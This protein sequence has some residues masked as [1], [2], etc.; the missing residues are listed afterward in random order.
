MLSIMFLIKA[1]RTNTLSKIP[2]EIMFL[3]IWCWLSESTSLFPSSDAITV[4]CS[5]LMVWP[6]CVGCWILVFFNCC[7]HIAES[8]VALVSKNIWSWPALFVSVILELLSGEHS[9]VGTI[10]K[11]L[12]VASYFRLVLFMMFSIPGEASSMVFLTAGAMTGIRGVRL[13]TAWFR[14][15]LTRSEET[16]KLFKLLRQQILQWKYF[17][18]FL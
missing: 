8:P 15:F 10:A 1:K 12:F 5:A 2:S 13:R 18:A 9:F 7:W 4:S 3:W 16:I 14:I 11:S 6:C 17:S